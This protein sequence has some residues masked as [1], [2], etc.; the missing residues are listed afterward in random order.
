[1][2][3]FNGQS[4]AGWTSD[5]G[6]FERRGDALSVQDNVA[7]SWS[8][9]AGTKVEHYRFACA[10]A[11]EHAPLVEIQ[12]AFTGAEADGYALRVEGERVMLVENAP[13][14]QRLIAALDPRRAQVDRSPDHACPISIERQPTHWWVFFEGELV[15]RVR[16]HEQPE[17]HR[18]RFIVEGTALF[19]SIVVEELVAPTPP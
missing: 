11:L 16:V 13:G 15:G 4:I 10:V 6:A 5:G 2:P 1:M 3:L 14:K 8:W 7:R 9:P 17:Q 12:F 18:V 19:D